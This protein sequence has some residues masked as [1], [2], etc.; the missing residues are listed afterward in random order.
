MTGNC[1]VAGD[2]D[3]I[4]LRA[5]HKDS[6]ARYAPAEQ[7]AADIERYLQE[8]PVLARGASASTGTRRTTISGYLAAGVVEC[9]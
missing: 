3:A 7:L 5:M 2:L 8:W 1:D 6:Q 4:P 9:L